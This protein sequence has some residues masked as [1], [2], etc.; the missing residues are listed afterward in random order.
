MTRRPDLK[1]AAAMLAAIS[2]LAI[3][4]MD[5]S[6]A[7]AQ[8]TDPVAE[9]KAIIWA[10]EKAIYA[11]RAEGDMGYYVANASPAYMSWPPITALPER[12]NVT[13]ANANIT[14]KSGNK[15]K[16]ENKLVDF[17]LDGDTALIYYINHRTARGDGTP[18]DETFSN[19]HVWVKRKGEW[20]LL[21]GMARPTAPPIR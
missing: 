9:A 3:V 16:I 8:T 6:A 5:A 14:L 11:H 7:L 10:K 21:G 17:T 2:A 15:E 18:V 12:L 20:L 4:S 13:A 19:I 1:T